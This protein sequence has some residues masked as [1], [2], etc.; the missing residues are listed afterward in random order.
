MSSSSTIFELHSEKDVEEF[1]RT[2]PVKRAVPA[3]DE[4]DEDTDT[5]PP[6]E[7][8]AK[9]E[10]NKKDETVQ[11]TYSLKARVSFL[12]MEQVFG[13]FEGFFALG[14]VFP[15][16]NLLLK[17]QKG[18]NGPLVYIISC[19][20]VVKLTTEEASV[21]ERCLD[22]MFIREG[23]EWRCEDFDDTL[24][25]IGLN[26]GGRFASAVNGFKLTGKLQSNYA[27]L[28]ISKRRSTQRKVP[29][30]FS[31]LMKQFDIG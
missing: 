10:P 17:K 6:N 11:F 13:I 7:K 20:L 8:K 27:P 3:S 29:S 21:F 2:P 28:V 25:E 22:M 15:T 1:L 12:V 4:D 16:A 30:P 26:A 19:I 31:H 9:G 14:K 5:Q 18:A 24:S 23:P